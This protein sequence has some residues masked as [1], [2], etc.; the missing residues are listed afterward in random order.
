MSK[1]TLGI[2][3]VV[4]I[5]AVVGMVYFG[6]KKDF[7]T[8]EGI[9][10][11]GIDKDSL[12]GMMKEKG[13][14]VMSKSEFINECK[15][16]DKDSQDMCYGM[17]AIY[18]R[19]ASFCKWIQDSE[20]KSNCTKENIEEYYNTLKEGGT[21]F[22]F[23]PSGTIP[24]GGIIPSG[25]AGGGTQGGGG[26]EN[27]EPE[28]IPSDASSQVG[29]I[30]ELSGKMTDEIYIEILAQTAYYAQKHPND[31]MGF[32]SYMKDLYNKY[33]ITEEGI[34]AFGKELEKN[35]QHAGEIG[36]KYIQRLQELQATG[37]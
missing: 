23:A 29:P 12:M 27:A 37:K 5:V 3:L 35:P 11:G 10:I 7:F 17:G 32:V 8:G 25:G 33:G 24:G 18:Y 2:I 34:T 14:V 31:S 9:G 19:D 4:L 26:V 1:K 30:V 20:A 13:E 6:F 15:K 21:M 16:S 22:P 36:L 28:S